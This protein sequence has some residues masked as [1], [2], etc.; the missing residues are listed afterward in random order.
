MTLV[1]GCASFWVGHFGH[2]VDIRVF[3]GFSLINLESVKVFRPGFP[4][5]GGARVIMLKKKTI[6][7]KY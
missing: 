4:I 7:T 1:V 6:P 3:A 2:V 5:K